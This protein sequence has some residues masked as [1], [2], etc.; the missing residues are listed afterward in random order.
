MTPV[1]DALRPRACRPALL[2]ALGLTLLLTTA[3]TIKDWSAL[4][5]MRLPD[6]DDMMRIAEIRDW[7]GGQRFNDLMQY[8]LGPPGGAP[9]HWSRLADAVPAAMILIL[10][11]LLGT[12]AAEVSAVI[13]WPALLFLCYLLLAGRIAQ[14]VHG[15][16]ARPVAVV[17]AALA[18]PTISLF[19]PGRIDHH[20]LQIVLM[21]ALVDGLLRRPSLAT[22]AAMGVIAAASL[23]IG[24]ESAPELVAVMAALGWLWL[25]GDAGEDRRA[26]GFGLALA[27]ATGVM[28]VFMHPDAWPR[29]WCDGFTPASTSATLALGAG[30]GVLGLAGRRLPTLPLRLATAAVVGI[31]VALSVSRTSMVCLAGPY[32]AL[33]PFLKEVWMSNVSEARGL[34]VGQDT[35]GTVLAYGA[36]SL[37]GSALAVIQA[38]R[39]GWRGRRAIAFAIVLVISAVAAILQ[40]R[41]T[42]ILAGLASIPF[43]VAIAATQRRPERMAARLTLWVLGAGVTYLAISKQMDTALAKPIEAARVDA[44]RCTAA[45]QFV[46]IARQPRGLVAAPIDLGSYL[47]GMTPHHVLAAGYHRNNDGNM[48]AYRFFLSPPARSAA[49]ARRM[50][51][52]YVALCPANMREIALERY[53][54]GSLVD[55]LQ[56]GRVPDWLEPVPA[57][58]SMLFF[59]VRE[60]LPEPTRRL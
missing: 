14:R 23:A 55:A 37:L 11:P 17:L 56:S 48:A 36:L 5:W 29:E 57:G 27:G 44:R 39:G 41:V 38:V 60:R 3:W 28:L 15:P 54:S 18:F 22:G 4:R 43:A 34:F 25:T 31:A 2:L 47:I 33:T 24:L 46:T 45:E 21:L 26:L 53:R 49:M 16:A 58:G 30:W 20:A 32:D 8:R 1:P 50:G 51:V 42:Y 9:M 40:I 35:P 12:H 59:R 7:I 13:A 10:T 52:D 6:N 19:V